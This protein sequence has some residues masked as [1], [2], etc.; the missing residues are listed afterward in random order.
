MALILTLAA[1]VA[2]GC[3]ASLIAVTAPP[4]NYV[5]EVTGTGATTQVIR[6]QN[7]NLDIT[8]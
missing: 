2:A 7:V 1:W 6:S 8:K 4:G 5:I 3:G